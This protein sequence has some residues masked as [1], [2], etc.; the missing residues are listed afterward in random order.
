LHIIE[1]LRGEGFSNAKKIA[2]LGFE[3]KIMAFEK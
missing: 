2:E 3:L 1:K